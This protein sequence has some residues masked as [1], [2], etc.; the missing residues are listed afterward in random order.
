MNKR[1]SRFGPLGIAM[2][3]SPLA[4]GYSAAAKTTT[5]PADSIVSVEY[6]D[7]AH[8]GRNVLLDEYLLK[9]LPVDER[10]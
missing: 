5:I 2:L 8:D 9:V 10:S 4:S 1:I 3:G 7:S 6:I